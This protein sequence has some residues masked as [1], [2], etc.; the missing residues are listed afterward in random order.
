M[1]W[2]SKRSPSPSSQWHVSLRRRPP[3]Q[4]RRSFARAVQSPSLG[5]LPIVTMQT[6]HAGAVSGACQRPLTP[7]QMQRA[8][9]LRL[10]RAPCAEAELL[11]RIEELNHKLAWRRSRASLA[12]AGPQFCYMFLRLFYAPAAGPAPAHARLAA[13]GHVCTWLLAG[14]L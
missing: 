5:L 12:A 6:F 7:L 8:A 1:Q 10:R 13:A 4:K 14:P 11:R 2:R 3:P 9:P